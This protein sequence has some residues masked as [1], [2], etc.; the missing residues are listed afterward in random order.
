MA[1][2]LRRFLVVAG[3]AGLLLTSGTA[4]AQVTP[5]PP[6]PDKPVLDALPPLEPTTTPRPVLRN[7]YGEPE[8]DEPRPP[9]PGQVDD[10]FR[11]ARPPQPTQVPTATR[12]VAPTGGTP[13]APPATAPPVE[14]AEPK[15]FVGGNP[16]LGFTSAYGVS[17]F[18]AGVAALLGYRV[19]DKI[20]IG[21]G[22][23]Y[24]YASYGGVGTT[25]IGAR[26]FGQFLISDAVFAHVEHEVL[27]ADVPYQI[28]TSSS[29]YRIEIRKRTFNS[30]FAGLGY[31]QYLGSRTMLDF[32]VLYNFNRSENALVYGQP[33]FRFNLLFNLNWR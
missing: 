7:E 15:W 2:N 20:A 28:F 27:R 6:P 4:R 13:T 9:Q 17:Y 16:T 23:T 24:Q 8:R 10:G 30:S 32:M 31:R 26:A 21:P 29:T 11:P 3:C 18:N 1:F 14:T 12:P 5:T 19:N 33:E 25:N 22:L